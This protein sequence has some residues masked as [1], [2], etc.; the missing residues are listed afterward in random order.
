M[1]SRRMRWVG[2]W[3]VWG[4]GEV[5]TEFWWGNMSE[6]DHLKDLDVDLRKILKWIF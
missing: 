6:R 4:R 2:H 3:H 1:K 5:Q